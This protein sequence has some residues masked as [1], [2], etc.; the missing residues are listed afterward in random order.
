MPLTA[1]IFNLRLRSILTASGL[2]GQNFSS[3]SFRRGGATWGLQC[4]LSQELIMALGDWKS[5]AFRGYL[6]LTDNTRRLAVDTMAS[7]IL[8]SGSGVGGFGQFGA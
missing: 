1:G 5:G 7:L 4:G 8:N 6:D 3:H 2:D